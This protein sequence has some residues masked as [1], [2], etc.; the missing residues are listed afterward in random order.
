MY[1]DIVAGGAN[2]SVGLLEEQVEAHEKHP[3]LQH[4]HS[5]TWVCV[6]VCAGAGESPCRRA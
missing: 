5:I 4:H 3:H 2:G 6:C 1:V